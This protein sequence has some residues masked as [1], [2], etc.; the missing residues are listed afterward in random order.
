GRRGDRQQGEGEARRTRGAE[1]RQRAEGGKQGLD[2]SLKQGG[3]EKSPGTGG[4]G[5]PGGGRSR[6]A[7]EATAGGKG[8]AERNG[9]E[10]NG[11]EG[12]GRAARTGAKDGAH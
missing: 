4:A 9:G 1:P 5:D 2:G 3:A 10:P 6:A 7:E 8:A 12:N 11:K